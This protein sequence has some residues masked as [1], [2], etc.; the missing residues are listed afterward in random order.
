MIEITQVIPAIREALAMGKIRL[1][2]PTGIQALDYATPLKPPRKLTLEQ[3][4]DP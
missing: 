2:M 1:A 4:A 3:A